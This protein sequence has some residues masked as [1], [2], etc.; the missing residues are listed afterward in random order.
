MSLRPF[1]VTAAFAIVAMLA[2][3]AWAWPQ[4]PDAAQVPVHWGLDGRPDG[5]APKAAALLG[6]PALALGIAALLAI[7]PR[8]EPRRENLAR[9]A[10]AYR[11][12]A[13]AVLV[14]LAVV[15][16]TAV[17]ASTGRE[18][19]VAAAVAASVGLLF[20]VIGNYLGKVRSNFMF[21]LRTPW[22]L[23]SERSWNR[24]H[25][26]AGRLMVLLGLAIVVAV[27]IGWR[28]ALLFAVLGAGL[29]A[30]VVG[31]FVYSYRV[32]RDDPDRRP[33]ANPR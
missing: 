25:R 23:T 3:S 32:W 30:V 7:V 19:D 1:F 17:V 33:L 31:T 22:T 28:G 29:A 6:M 14:V 18:V 13:S 4:I 11:I 12:V 16:A 5:F 21:G 27:V 15:H 20:A 2:I 26:L 9:S 10:G 8:V 24:T